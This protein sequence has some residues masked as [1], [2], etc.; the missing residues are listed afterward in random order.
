MI[1]PLHDVAA[2]IGGRHILAVLPQPALGERD[3]VILRDDDAL[4]QHSH[5]RAGTVRWRPP[6]HQD[7]LRVMADHARHEMHVGWRVI[8]LGR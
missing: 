7:R 5:R 8:L 4:A 1:H 6:R 3:L 2:R